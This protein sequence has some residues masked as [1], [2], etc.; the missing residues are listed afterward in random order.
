[1]SLLERSIRIA[2]VAAALPLCAVV[3]G[4][5]RPVEKQDPDWDRFRL[6]STAAR[7]YAEEAVH[8]D[9]PKW[10][11]RFLVECQQQTRTR[12]S[13]FERDTL[14]QMLDQRDCFTKRS[15]SYHGGCDWF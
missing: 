1:M 10:N 15:E 11:C 2:V 5:G 7:S 13:A 6:C 12:L 3:A 4:C 9:K 8:P 14:Q